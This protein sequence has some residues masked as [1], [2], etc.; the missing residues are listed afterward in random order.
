M[1]GNGRPLLPRARGISA[2]LSYRYFQF[3]A[4]S[5]ILFPVPAGKLF[6]GRGKF[7]MRPL[8]AGHFHGERSIGVVFVLPTRPNDI[9]NGRDKLQTTVH[10][11]DLF[12][13]SRVFLP[14]VGAGRAGAVS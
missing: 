3:H 11:A 5:H 14:A 8:S 6:I 13:E 10:P 9:G 12:R 2:A 4:R 7:R 1:Y